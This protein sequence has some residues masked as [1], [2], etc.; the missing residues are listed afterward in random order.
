MPETPNVTNYILYNK[1]HA[2][3]SFRRNW[4]RLAFMYALHARSSAALLRLVLPKKPL[5]RTRTGALSYRGSVAPSP[6]TPPSTLPPPRRNRRRHLHNGQRCWGRSWPH[7]ARVRSPQL[8][9]TFRF[10]SDVATCC[11]YIHC[12]VILPQQRNK[13]REVDPRFLDISKGSED[14]L[15]GKMDRA[16]HST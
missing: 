4:L 15:K 8:V 7:V 1:Y 3:D 2:R 12:K 14:D 9:A 5:P 11:P 6:S 16:V 10:L 13:G